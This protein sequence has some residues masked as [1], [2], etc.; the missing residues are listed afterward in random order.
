MNY[1]NDHVWIS[2]TIILK[3]RAVGFS[4]MNNLLNSYYKQCKYCSISKLNGDG[5]YEYPKCLSAEEKLIKD[6]IE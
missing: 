1:S 2:G 3:Y 5:N 6:I 4:N